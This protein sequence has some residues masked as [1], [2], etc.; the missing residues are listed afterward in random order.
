MN[1]S[2][3]AVNPV[4]PLPTKL[5]FARLA[6]ISP[7][8]LLSLMGAQNPESARS[9]PPAAAE[10][11]EKS[12]GN[13]L[14]SLLFRP[15]DPNPD[16]EMTVVTEMT[17]EGRKLPAVSPEHP[18]YYQA[19]SSGDREMGYTAVAHEQ[20][21]PPEEAEP[22]LVRGLAASGYRPAIMPEHPPSVVVFYFWGT[23]NAIDPEIA[24]IAP[25]QLY[26][27]I[28][29]RALLVGGRK[30]S[31]EI[32]EVVAETDLWKIGHV[33]PPPVVLWEMRKPDNERLLYQALGDVY[34]VVASAFDYQSV[35]KNRPVL[36]WRTHMTVSSQGVWM[37]TAL[38]AVVGLAGK[39]FGR[40]M[41]E[42]VII[43]KSATPD[44]KVEIGTPTVVDPPPSSRDPEKK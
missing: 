32:A 44:G 26:R 4:S 41:T 35:A 33:G 6:C 24:A 23:H 8:L 14:S 17:D 21:M 36:L 5:Q 25:N 11:S 16:M 22:L 42:P 34:Y 20:T 18:A 27:N 37:K 40:E 19:H 1:R 28:L 9:A 7:L 15:F 10:E 3:D 2:R 31:N 39:Y 29:D 43:R 12:S 13:W 30:F 38:P